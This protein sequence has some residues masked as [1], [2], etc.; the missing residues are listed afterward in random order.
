MKFC[1][2]HLHFCYVEQLGIHIVRPTPFYRGLENFGSE[3]KGGTG[4]KFFKG[5]E[6]QYKR[7]TSFKRGGWDSR[8]KIFMTKFKV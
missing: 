1:Y 7:G 4:K 6:S 2:V 5:K 8:G 3:T